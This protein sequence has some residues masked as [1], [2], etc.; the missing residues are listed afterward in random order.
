ML[1]FEIAAKSGD[2]TAGCCREGRFAPLLGRSEVQA[3]DQRL[4]WVFFAGVAAEACR[5]SQQRTPS[6]FDDPIDDPSGMGHAQRGDGREGVKDVAHG[7]E[8]DHKQAELGLRLQI[9]IFSQRQRLLRG[10]RMLP[11]NAHGWGYH[12]AAH[13]LH[14]FE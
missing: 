1:A 10:E 2:F 8:T 13:G 14:A 5:G 4:R 9:L 7:A 11:L 12:S 3:V 6:G